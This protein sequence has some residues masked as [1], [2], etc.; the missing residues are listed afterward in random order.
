MKIKIVSDPSKRLGRIT[1]GDNYNASVMVSVESNRDE[2]DKEFSRSLVIEIQSRID[3]QFQ[4]TIN[5]C[6]V[7]Q[8]QLDLLIGE[9]QRIKPFLP[10]WDSNDN[11]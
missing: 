2:N 5:I 1:L 9:L 8:R 3:T 4:S 7:S 10:M 11:V 6:G